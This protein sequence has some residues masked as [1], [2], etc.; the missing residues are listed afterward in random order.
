MFSRRNS[1]SPR[2]NT[3]PADQ[4]S[5]QCSRKLVCLR[6]S[7]SSYCTPRTACHAPPTTNRSVINKYKLIYRAR[8]TNRGIFDKINKK[9]LLETFESNPSTSLRR[10]NSRY[11]VAIPKKGSYLP[12]TE[13]GVVD[14]VIGHGILGLVI[15]RVN[16]FDFP[17]NTA[18]RLQDIAVFLR[19]VRQNGNH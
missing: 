9:T 18:L 4:K 7:I 15:G 16:G 14:D 5:D 19:H 1:P 11:V 8:N 13:L 6:P 2:R 12:Y 10:Q 17:D 3:R